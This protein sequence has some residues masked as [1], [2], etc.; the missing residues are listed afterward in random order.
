MAD[1]ATQKLEDDEPLSLATL[2]RQREFLGFILTRKRQVTRPSAPTYQRICRLDPFPLK[3]FISGCER[4]DYLQR[5]LWGQKETART[6]V[7]FQD[8]EF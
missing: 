3:G 8:W 2:H 5:L 4:I 7:F 1:I 6:Y